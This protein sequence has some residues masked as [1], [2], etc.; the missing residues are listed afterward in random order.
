MKVRVKC[1]VVVDVLPSKLKTPRKI[2]LTTSRDYDLPEPAGSEGTFEAARCEMPM[3]GTPTPVKKV[4]RTELGYFTQVADSKGHYPDGLNVTVPGSVSGELSNRIA[5]R[6]AATV[7]TILRDKTVKFTPLPDGRTPDDLL[8]LPDIE[9]YD[10]VVVDLQA[11]EAQ[12]LVIDEIVK[13]YAVVRSTLYRRTNEPFY[14]VSMSESRSAPGTMPYVGMHLVTDGKPTG[15]T[16]AVFR[17]G[18]LDDALEFKSMLE[19]AGAKPGLLIH[20][21]SKF[22]ESPEA[23][24][25]FADLDMTIAIAAKRTSDAFESSFDVFKKPRETLKEAIYDV[26]LEQIATARRLRAATADKEFSEIAVQADQLVDLL[27]EVASY[28]DRSRFTR[29]TL[30]LA[31]VLSL[32]ENRNIDVDFSPITRKPKR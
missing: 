27:E 9:R 13:E 31:M 29:E 10:G 3:A 2:V 1:P 6:T 5:T 4:F 20:G 17:L 18:R 28:G 21:H 12:L 16:V 26:P 30:P 32:W 7:E 14:A 19:E 24:S 25:D 15:T 22:E 8:M 11:Y 23:V